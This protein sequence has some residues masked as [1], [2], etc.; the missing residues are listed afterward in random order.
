MAIAYFSRVLTQDIETVWA[1]L[2]DFHGIHNWVSQIT[3]SRAVDGAGRGPVGSIRQ[4][5]L[6]DGRE[7]GERLV[8]YDASQYT[9][10]YEFSDDPLPFPMRRFLA[11]IRLRPVTLEQACFLEWYA[12]YDADSANE[13]MLRSAF[14]D[15]YKAFSDNLIDALSLE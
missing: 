11:T 14:T 7:V 15:R 3:D 4:L 12:D 6:K 9:Y 13:S 10:S 1:V 2:G 8:A 5:T